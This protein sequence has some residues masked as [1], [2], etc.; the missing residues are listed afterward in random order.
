MDRKNPKV[1]VII[2]VY[3]AEKYLRQCL[4]SIVNQTLKDVEIICVNDGSTDNSLDIL[5]QY[6]AKDKR[7]KVYNKKNTGPADTRN[8]GLKNATGEY[9]WFVDADDECARN[10]CETIY[11]KMSQNNLDVFCFCAEVFDEKKKEKVENNWYGAYNKQIPSN[12]LE[13][14]LEFD[15]YLPFCFRVNGVLWNK[16]FSHRFVIN[17]KI[18]FNSKLYIEDDKLFLDNVLSNRPKALFSLSKLYMYRQNFSNNIVGV[19]RTA[20]RKF[21]DIFIFFTDLVS[22][23]K[24]EKN[25]KYKSEIFRQIVSEM[26]QWG[27]VAHPDNKKEFMRR[28]LAFI[29]YLKK[30]FPSSVFEN[31]VTYDRCVSLLTGGKDYNFKV[32]S[33]KLFGVIIHETYKGNAVK[34]KKLFGLKYFSKKKKKDKIYYKILGIPLY[35][36]KKTPIKSVNKFLGLPIYSQK[37]SEYKTVKKLLGIPL[38]TKKKTPT[39][40]IKRFLS[41]PFYRKEQKDSKKV[42][43]FFGIPVKKTIITPEYKKKYFLG[44]CYRREQQKNETL[45]I[46]KE[47]DEM[48]NRIVANVTKNMFTT[49]MQSINC[50]EGQKEAFREFKGTL[51]NKKFVLLATG[52]TVNYFHPIPNAVYGGCNRAFQLSDYKLD[53]LFMHDWRAVKPYVDGINKLDCIKFF[54]SHLGLFYMGEKDLPLWNQFNIPEDFFIKH[55]DVK[56]Y[57]L[58]NP[59]LK[60]IYPNLEGMPLYC[61]GSVAHI[62]FQFALYAGAK[63]IYL[64]GCDTT[65]SGYFDN[66]KQTYP[67]AVAP[68]INGYKNLKKFAQLYYPE[69]E[70][71][72]V[73]PVGLKGMFRDVYTEA[74]LADHPEIDRNSVEIL[75]NLEKGD[76]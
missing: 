21:F 41:V 70:I 30:I 34:Y 48:A 72:S 53:Y 14:Q 62:V 19:M 65:M 36:K 50:M 28:G 33:K 66:A 25:L 44:V 3:N 71:I 17:N 15:E 68:T 55:K 63:Q 73:N 75:E 31:N 1:S 18:S 43:K 12:L 74:Y 23:S 38:Y 35:I 4:D 6:A 9:L 10:A 32:K 46:K 7:F 27:L 24:K 5:N 51:Q 49:V 37:K 52:P 76:A 42:T 67:L 54:G 57:Y 29:D 13:K 58:F 64:V 61:N 59:F 47:I 60:T 8:I 2:P 69:T 40:L 11:N 22:L 26:Y 16:S 56:R 20:D 39:K 45:N